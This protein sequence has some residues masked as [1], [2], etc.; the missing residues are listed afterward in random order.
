MYL[1]SFMRQPEQQEEMINYLTRLQVCMHLNVSQMNIND[2][3][4]SVHDFLSLFIS[5]KQMKI[6]STV[7]KKL[8]QCVDQT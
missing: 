4:T 8:L 5:R 3:Q 2:I 6:V 1:L 7:L